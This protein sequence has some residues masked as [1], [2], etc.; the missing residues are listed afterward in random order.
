MQPMSI[1]SNIAGRLD[2]TRLAAA[3]AAL[4]AVVLSAVYASQHLGGLRPCTLCLYQRWPWWV[5]LGLAVLA[6]ALR[7]RAKL[8]MAVIGLASMTLLVGAG[9]AVFHVG[10]EQHWWQG[11]ASCGG[12]SDMP[13]TVEALK[14]QIMSAPVVRCDEVAWSFLGISMAGYNALISMAA[15]V[16]GLYLAWRHGRA[17]L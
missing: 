9:I 1:V 8:Q 14:K 10:V 12:V 13:T 6:M 3:K 17:A 4:G 11:L 7:G 16:G 15:G 5:A 2:M